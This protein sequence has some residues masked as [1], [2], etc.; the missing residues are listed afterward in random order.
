MNNF[1][2]IVDP[3]SMKDAVNQLNDELNKMSHA[4]SPQLEH[5]LAYMKS[6]VG[7]RRRRHTKKAKKSGKKTRKH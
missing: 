5:T 6:Q 3:A 2:V 7:A 4:K 1:S